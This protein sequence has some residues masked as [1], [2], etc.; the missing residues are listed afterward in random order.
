MEVVL[1]QFVKSLAASGLMSADE[2]EVF[3]ERL[4]PEKKPDDGAELAR[5]LVRQGKLTKF[6]AQAIYQGKAKGLI[7]GDYVVLDRIGEGGMGQVYKAEHRTMERVVA[8]KTLPSAATKS[9][10]AVQRF[11]REV[12]VAARLSHPNIVTAYDAGE[13]QG[14]H[15]LVMEHVEG[16]D[17]SVLVRTNGTLTV[18]QALN[19]ILQAA[20]GLEYAHAENV[21]HRDIKPSN[22]LLDRKGT[23]KVLDMGLARLNQAVGPYDETAD[24]TLT[25]TGQAM[26]TIDF[27]PPEQAENTKSADERSD[28]YSLGCSLYY[29]LTGRA[30][31]DG[32]TVV[33][34]LL[35]H[36]E[37]EIPLLRA[38]RPNVPEKLDLIYQKMVAKRPDDRYGS[39]TEVI[40]ELEECAAPRPEQFDETVDLE[41]QRLSSPLVATQPVIASERTPADESLP[42]DLPVISPV[43]DSRPARPK[44]VKLNRQQI[45]YGSMVAV[46]C[47]LLLFL[48]VVFTLKTPEGTLVVTVDEPDAEVLV[49]DEKVTIKSPGE[50]SIEIEVM[51]G[52]HTLRVRK[53]GFQTFTEE[54]AIESGGKETIS[55]EL[56][57][58]ERKVEARPKPV[59]TSAGGNWALEFDGETSYVTISG[60]DDATVSASSLEAWVTPKELRGDKSNPNGKSLVLYCSGMKIA[61]RN[62]G[63]WEYSSAQAGYLK[64]TVEVVVGH[65]VHLAGCWDGEEFRFY[66]DGRLQKAQSGL[67][68]PPDYASIGAFLQG[69]QSH[70]HGLIDEIRISSIARY[71]EDFT[72]QSHFEPDE[73][74]MS[75]YHFDEGS[76]DVLKDSSGNGHHGKIVGAKWV[77]VDEG[78]RV[79]DVSPDRRAAE[80]V[81]RIGGRI[82]IAFDGKKVLVEAGD[83][84]PRE[85]FVVAYVGLSHNALVKDEH[86]HNL[87]GLTALRELDLRATAVGDTGLK[88]LG[89]LR[90]LR[91]L[92]LDSTRVTDEGLRHL[93]AMQGLRYLTFV[94]TAASDAGLEH[95][96]GLRQLTA[97]SLGSPKEAGFASLATLPHLAALNIQPNRTLTDR[98]TATLNR[99]PK[100]TVLVLNHA[101]VDDGY[102]ECLSQLTKIR[103]LVLIGSS[104]T[105]DGFAAL[106]AALPKC[107]I[108]TDPDAWLRVWRALLEEEG[109]PID[110]PP[111]PAI[112]PFTPAQAKQH[113]KA[114]AD[115][116]GVPV[117]FSNSI[118]M[119]MVLIPPGE[120]LMGSSEEEIARTLKE[121]EE[122]G[123]LEGYG[124]RIS[125]EDPQHKVRINRAFY[126]AAHELTVGQ[127]TAFVEAT[128][129]RTAVEST[130]KLGSGR[131]EIDGELRSAEKPEFSWRNVGI[132]QTDQHPVSNLT[133]NDAL[134]FCRLLAEKEGST[135]RLPTESE[136][137][138]ACRAGSTSRWF[139]GDDETDLRQYAWCASRDGHY[140]KPV[141]QLAANGFGL[142]DMC[143]NVW[144][145]CSDFYSPDYYGASPVDDPACLSSTDYPV[146]RG[147]AAQ[148][149]T[150]AVRSAYRFSHHRNHVDL[151]LGF[152]PVR[153]IDPTDPKPSPKPPV[154]E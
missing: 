95:L 29:L 109:S 107:K 49:D 11:H 131:I 63:R 128:G 88:N 53:G 61:R 141:G 34:K 105:D 67:A 153:L 33:M 78:L 51:E 17:L 41:G 136:W 65:P 68:A 43:D 83:G 9:E 113:Q 126:F 132:E 120:F 23:V 66:L 75:L 147:G 115:H 64:S 142:Y 116:L 129:Y 1:S 146:S 27:M 92:S 89:E 84:L 18:Q 100:L 82:M 50:E 118:G 7:L 2:I 108:E 114:W 42:L 97:L 58:V 62:G 135:Y 150:W 81:L 74:T 38:E 117:E 24:E 145:M 46:V 73:H 103:Q 6:Q 56:R 148:W 22:L 98:N 111:P 151:H 69:R 20:R 25:G 130:D 55:V 4:P 137:E 44:Q 10:L 154:E 47:F 93:R 124:E 28:I 14:V 87:R 30:I 133:W 104:I 3:I 36:R 12:K 80:W 125:S 90:G 39:M 60:L 86:L 140:S 70:F 143:G 152:R 119:K 76:G 127:F 101:G 72:P 77:K 35:A 99:F 96:K 26:G 138:Y 112:A 121:A 122:T 19:Y 57:P 54:F 91:I 45:I 32:D 52:K 85:D 59:A 48:G 71:T 102:I 15:Y 16:S 123:D 149:K 21:I 94:G 110:Q 106:K 134:A 8:L 31:F 144:E 13:S 79:V 5:E 139:F 37:A 40:A